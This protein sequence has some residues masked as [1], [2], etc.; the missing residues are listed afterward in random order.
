MGF[1]KDL[2]PEKRCFSESLI[3]VVTY[4]DNIKAEVQALA[5]D[6]QLELGIHSKPSWFF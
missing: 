5:D 1:E 6:R 4:N 2:T 3:G